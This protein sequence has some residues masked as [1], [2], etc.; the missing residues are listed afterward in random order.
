[1]FPNIK[2]GI[3]LKEA[4]TCR[5]IANIFLIEF[6]CELIHGALSNKG[7]RLFE[8]F[9]V[10]VS[11]LMIVFLLCAFAFMSVGKLLVNYIELQ[12]DNKLTV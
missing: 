7:D 11:V 1:M 10:R 4:R 6:L 5:L 3:T 12:E 2:D 8:V 9:N